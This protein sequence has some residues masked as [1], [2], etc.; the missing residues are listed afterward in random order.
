MLD[1][2]EKKIILINLGR[3]YKKFPHNELS[4]VKKAQLVFKSIFLMFID[5]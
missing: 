4:S 5:W 2:H 3:K 1:L